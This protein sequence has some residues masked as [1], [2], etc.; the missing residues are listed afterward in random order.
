MPQHPSLLQTLTAKIHTIHPGLMVPVIGFGAWLTTAAVL[1][2]IEP[3][4]LTES[5]ATPR[6]DDIGTTVPPAPSVCHQRR[7]I[8]LKPPV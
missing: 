5:G 3:R 1:V 2:L 7:E 6:Q 8:H 4:K